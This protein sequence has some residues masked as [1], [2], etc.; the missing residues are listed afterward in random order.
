MIEKATW[1]SSLKAYLYLLPMMAIMVVFNFYPIIKSFMLSFYTDYDFFNNQVNAVGTGNY[2]KIFHD[3]DFWLAL[4]NTFIFVF[5]SVPI[6]IVLALWIALMIHRIP[7]L[8]GLFRTVYFLPFVT[9]TVAITLV[10]SW[11]YHSR[12]GVFNYFL[13]WFGIQPIQWL[14]DP[15][16][17][18]T[19]LVIAAVWKNLGL[20][21]ILF[22]VGLT[23]IDEGYYAAARVDGAK[24]WAQFWNITVPLL[25]P[26][27]FLVMVTSTIGSFKV[28]DEVFAMFQGQPGPGKSALTIVYYIYQKFY[29]EFDY[30]VAAAA[31]TVLFGII[32]VIT[33]L[34]QIY[35]KTVAS[36]V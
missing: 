8:Q 24:T 15:K 25:A 13:G 28:F 11:M 30:G 27:T 22:L 7:Y 35:N 19:A 14:T 34:Q 9:S 1:K 20:A 31:G 18:M 6:G 29:T 36:K 32:L 4:K 21:I 12:F 33:C 23:N 17:A 16:Y 3:P 5:G 2:S 10:W 26:T